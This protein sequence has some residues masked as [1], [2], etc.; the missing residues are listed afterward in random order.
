MEKSASYMQYFCSECGILLKELEEFQ[1]LFTSTIEEECPKCGSSL[2]K[3]MKKKWKF[4][5]D[6]A[7]LQEQQQ[8][9]NVCIPITIGSYR[10]KSLLQQEQLQ[11]IRPQLLQTAYDFI[12]FAPLDLRKIDSCLNCP[13]VGESLCIIGEQEHANMLLTRLYVRALMSRRE[14][15]FDSPHVILIDAGNNSDVYQCINF[16]R[17]YGL[18]IKNILQRI[19]VSRAFTIYQL[20]NLIIYELAEVI[21]KYDTK[22][23]IASNLLDMFTKDPN[24]DYREA[25]FLIKE[26][27]NSLRKMMRMSNILIVVS[28][29]VSH[30]TNSNR[31]HDHQSVYSKILL[32]KFDKSIQISTSKVNPLLLD[33]EI[34]NNKNIANSKYGRSKFNRLR[35]HE[36]ELKIIRR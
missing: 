20:A 25:R 32:P 9:T 11:P 6:Q 10:G 2:S 14:G 19:I 12:G 27:I 34:N 3:S 21:K 31:N 23:I 8:N 13:T 29:S 1:D 33:L 16:A 22:I 30:N 5:S 4:R 36:K 7:Q 18:N 28:F 24:I 17:Q 15:G 26:I 35:L